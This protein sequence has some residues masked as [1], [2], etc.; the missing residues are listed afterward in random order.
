M[1]ILVTGWPGRGKTTTARKLAAK[2]GLKHY[3]VDI[4]VGHETKNPGAPIVYIPQ[5]LGWSEGSQYA[6]DHW[7]GKLNDVVIE[8]NA[9]P[10]VL[11]KWRA[12]NPDR[13]P[14]CDRIVL[15]TR[16]FREIGSGQ[17]AM[18]KGHDTIL[19]EIMPW[20]SHMVERDPE[21]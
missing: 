15:L 11:R 10:R 21:I 9:I 1:I 17:M 14:P 6:V 2:H 12:Q 8:G 20:I 3:S 13:K 19:E 18:G 4:E 5:N 7:I 16:Q